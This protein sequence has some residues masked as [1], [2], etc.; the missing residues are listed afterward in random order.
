MSTAIKEAE[1]VPEGDAV[2]T[3]VF[4]PEEEAAFADGFE[5]KKT[6]P[7]DAV[8]VKGGIEDPPKTE[9]PPIPEPKIVQL[10]EEKY[11]ELLAQATTVQELKGALEQFKGTAFGKM[12]GL[13][14][15]IKEIQTAG[16]T[17][18]AVTIAPEDLAELREIY[19]EVTEELE[20][21]L[22]RIMGKVKVGSPAVVDAA[23]LEPILRPLIDTAVKIAKAETK[24][25]AATERLTERHPNWV[26]IVGAKDS[27]TDFRKW[28]KGTKTPEE[29]TKILDTWSPKAA[30]D[31]IDEFLE[32]QKK[33]TTRPKPDAE[34]RRARIEQG[35]QPR[36]SAPP[37]P[38]TPTVED[39]FN[40][41]FAKGRS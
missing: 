12:G 18:A 17:G 25:E 30:G 28:L 15:T 1:V 35:I 8:P 6:P 5:G 14:R 40:E 2:E 7:E 19:P 33:T 21:G 13:E 20:K 11:Q 38:K 29:Q 31:V 24:Q 37:V 22:A 9:D 36:G 4:S 26:E 27:E 3:V 23:T 10:T 32:H 41:G 16:T 39:A 34:S